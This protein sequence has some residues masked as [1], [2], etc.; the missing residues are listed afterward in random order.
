M[1]LRDV[2]GY[3]EVEV[4]LLCERQETVPLKHIGVLL[5]REAQSGRR[6]EAG[7]KR[8]LGLLD[9]LFLLRGA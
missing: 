5:G 4:A 8:E 7:S 3:S 9:W 2:K 1:A 6:P